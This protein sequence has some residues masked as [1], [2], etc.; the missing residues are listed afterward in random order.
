MYK[1]QK[2]LNKHQRDIHNIF[3]E[4]NYNCSYNG[5]KETFKSKRKLQ[6]HKSAHKINTQ[7]LK[8]FKCEICSKCY[9]SKSYIK[10]HLRYQHAVNSEKTR[11]LF[12]AKIINHKK[13]N[14]K[15]LLCPIEKC[16]KKVYQYLL[17]RRHLMAIHNLPLEQES[18]EFN[19]QVGK[20][21]QGVTIQRVLSGDIRDDVPEDGRIERI[22]LIEKKR[23]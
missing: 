17:L 20:L 3:K 7:S 15:R 22:H 9:S 19:T 14:Q 4:I 21:S 18:Y 12:K 16:G 6:Y 23:Y 11:N 5:C 2:A 1:S 8:Q 13:L 10:Q